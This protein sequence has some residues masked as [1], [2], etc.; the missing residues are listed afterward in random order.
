MSSAPCQMHHKV[1]F[2]VC[3]NSPSSG[4]VAARYQRAASPLRSCTFQRSL[5][6]P[7]HAFEWECSLVLSK[8]T[9]RQ[10][11]LLAKPM[12]EHESTRHTQHNICRA[13]AHAIA[14]MPL[15]LCHRARR[16]MPAPS[17]PCNC[18]CACDCTTVPVPSCQ[19]NCSCACAIVPVQSFLCPNHRACATVCRDSLR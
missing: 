3:A 5:F 13:R 2:P 11:H 12:S 17:C 6:A 19:C 10:T 1:C 4:G 8:T 15:F 18:S 9:S 7:H 14:P 16:I